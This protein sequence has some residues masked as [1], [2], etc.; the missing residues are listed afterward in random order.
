[1]VQIARTKVKRKLLL[2]KDS[3]FRVKKQPVDDRKID[4][5]MRRKDI[6]EDESFCM[7][8]PVDGKPF[9]SN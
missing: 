3:Q 5:Y 7:A 4:R 9:V 6:I 2:G 1:M 8:S